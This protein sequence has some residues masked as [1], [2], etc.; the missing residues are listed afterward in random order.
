[1]V[2]GVMTALDGLLA[3]QSLWEVEG[4]AG[5]QRYTGLATAGSQVDEE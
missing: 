2:S 4:G 1:M 3:D 5:D